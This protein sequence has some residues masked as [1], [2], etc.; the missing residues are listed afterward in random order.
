LFPFC[1]Q[2]DELGCRINVHQQG[3]YE[4]PSFGMPHPHV[5]PHFQDDGVAASIPNFQEVGL[6]F[7][8]IDWPSSPPLFSP[9]WSG[10][11]I[12]LSIRVERKKSCLSISL[13]RLIMN[14]I[15]LIGPW[16]GLLDADIFFRVIEDW[17]WNFLFSIFFCFQ[18]EIEMACAARFST[19]SH[20]FNSIVKKAELAAQQTDDNCVR[21]FLTASG[22][23][24]S[25]SSFRVDSSSK[26]VA[27]PSELWRPSC[28]F[29]FWVY[30]KA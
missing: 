3:L 23:N 11:H 25:T 20:S 27:F 4:L 29:G 24:W 30:S 13:K 22:M 14:R 12:F 17:D 1:F 8:V 10:L 19:C 9:V 5:V 6:N 28:A 21:P 18:V 26:W 7:E 15:E 2:V 16:F